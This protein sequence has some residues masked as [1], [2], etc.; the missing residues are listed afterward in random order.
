MHPNLVPASSQPLPQPEEFLPIALDGTP[1]YQHR[2]ASQYLAIR[3][4]HALLSLEGL[5]V[6]ATG[7]PVGPGSVSSTVPILTKR[8]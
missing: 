1:R 2:H 6:D 4:Y 5:L 7:Q 3:H 8:L